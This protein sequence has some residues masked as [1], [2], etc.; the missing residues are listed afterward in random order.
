MTR[1]RKREMHATF[2]VAKPKRKRKLGRT[3]IMSNGIIQ[4]D[5]K[6]IW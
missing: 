2:L 4:M 3:T 1:I 5:H 6:E